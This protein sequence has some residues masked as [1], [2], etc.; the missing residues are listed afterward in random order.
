M[1]QSVR[2]KL[3]GSLPG[4]VSVALP[5]LIVIAGWMF[6]TARDY[7]ARADSVFDDSKKYVDRCVARQESTFT[8]YIDGRENAFEEI[9]EGQDS[10]AIN[11]AVLNGR[12][13]DL[14]AKQQIILNAILRVEGR[15]NGND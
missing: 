3:N 15:V 5:I 7:A 2:E 12:V 11:V 8:A 9:F 13:K 14:T 6:F 10:L 4:V 1:I